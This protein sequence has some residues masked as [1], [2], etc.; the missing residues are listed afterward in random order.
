MASSNEDTGIG[1]WNRRNFWL[2]ASFSL[3]RPPLLPARIRLRSVHARTPTQGRL[4]R[5]RPF[6]AST[7]VNAKSDV[8]LI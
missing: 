8:S 2:H 5:S 7:A 3:W 1:L 4:H 6:T